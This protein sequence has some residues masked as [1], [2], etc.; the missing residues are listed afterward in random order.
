MI[1]ALHNINRFEKTAGTRTA[2]LQQVA[3]LLK[4]GGVVGVVQHRAPADADDDWADGSNGYLKQAAVIA[5]F[6]QAG[7][8]LIDSSEINANAKD[9]PVVGDAVWRLPPSLRTADE[10]KA[11]MQAVGESD[12]MTLKF[13]KR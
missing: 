9:K 12:R 10:N 6:E 5:A 3:A 1:R 11:A 7:F 13:I 4:T 8:E 2:A